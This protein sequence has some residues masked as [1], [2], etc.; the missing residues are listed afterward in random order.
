MGACG[1]QRYTEQYLEPLMVTA[2]ILLSSAQ[3]QETKNSAFERY[4]RHSHSFL[5]GRAF[6]SIKTEYG[7]QTQQN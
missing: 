7:T 2:E 1:G 4:D 3:G 5:S 6:R